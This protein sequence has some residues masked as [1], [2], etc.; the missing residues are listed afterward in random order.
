MLLE[1]D[2]LERENSDVREI[3][4][5]LNKA[6]ENANKLYPSSSM[7]G[8]GCL[9]SYLN[10]LHIPNDNY[11]IP[12]DWEKI[13]EPLDGRFGKKTE[14]AVKCFQTFSYITPNGKVDDETYKRLKEFS[15]IDFNAIQMLGEQMDDDSIEKPDLSKARTL[16]S[17]TDICVDILRIFTENDVKKK[18]DACE[19]LSK[20][21]KE[22]K[23][24][25]NEYNNKRETRRKKRRR[26]R[27]AQL[28]KK[29]YA[30]YLKKVN[31]KFK[32]N[33][34]TSP[35]SKT[36]PNG[37][38]LDEFKKT[39]KDFL[40]SHRKVI[41]EAYEISNHAL[42]MKLKNVLNKIPGL[43]FGLILDYLYYASEAIYNEDIDKAFE[44]IAMASYYCLETL[45]IDTIS[46][47]NAKAGFFIGFTMFFVDYFFVNDSE[48]TLLPTRNVIREQYR[49][50]TNNLKIY[51][52]DT[53]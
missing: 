4:T 22:L 34:Y 32:S 1:R 48:D 53:M 14:N 19:R 45:G 3:Q 29:D 44:E 12:S 7:L 46:T 13:K 40:L 43:K 52:G 41:K 5:M 49:K 50:L 28:Y 10:T 38:L 9:N 6:L 20:T 18:K 21:T 35:Y 16:K 27:N 33:G 23:E 2:P 8:Y 31:E 51:I 25:Y 17:L 11:H 39:T 36:K 30:E 15:S 37:R 24:I 47:K 42:V 26:D